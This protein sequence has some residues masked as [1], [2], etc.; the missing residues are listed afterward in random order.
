MHQQYNLRIFLVSGK[1]MLNDVLLLKVTVS[2]K[3]DG[4]YHKRRDQQS[5]ERVKSSNIEIRT[6]DPHGIAARQEPGGII[7]RQDIDGTC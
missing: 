7:C 1:S 5:A 6:P 4:N 3:T 2:E